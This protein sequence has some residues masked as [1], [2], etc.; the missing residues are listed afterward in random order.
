MI[1][2]T[3]ILSF[4][5]LLCACDSKPLTQMECDTLTHMEIDF[6]TEGAGKDAESMRKSL[7]DGAEAGT[8][9]C[10]AGKTYSRS[11]YKCMLRA[12]SRT[13]KNECLSAVAARLRT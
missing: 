11:D 12:K 13:E 3:T 9:K 4:V 5:L 6:A 2:A 8:A 1:R 10:V 7:T